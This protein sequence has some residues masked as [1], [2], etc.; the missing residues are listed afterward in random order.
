MAAGCSLLALPWLDFSWWTIFR[1]CVSIGAALSLWVCV[2][3]LERRTWRSYGVVAF[4]VGAP[5]LLFG[6]ALGAVA[7]SAMLALG[8]ATGVCQLAVTPDRLKLWRTL[9]GFLPAAGLVGVL[10]E[11]V[12]RGFILQHFLP[13]SRVLAVVVSSALYA[14]VHLKTT[15][16]SL[17]TGF[18]LV[19][20]ALLGGV[21]ALSYLRTG[22]LS[23]AIG[24]HAALAYG[25]RVNKLLVAF[26]DPSLSWL[27]GTSRLVNG[28]VG[29]LILLGLGG[30]IMAWTARRRAD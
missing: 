19:G 10:E 24:L 30:I 2:T 23:L 16:W 12:F 1:R 21:L 5:H 15:I 3:K 18:E 25:A 14:V 27:I 26:P 9:I 29:W 6:M 4:R 8:L 11:L 17:A 28:V 7:L 22:Q 13:C 20:L